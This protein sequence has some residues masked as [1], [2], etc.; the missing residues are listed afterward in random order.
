MSYQLLVRDDSDWARG[1]YRLRDTTKGL[2]SAWSENIWMI[3]NPPIIANK[4]T[5]K[6]YI[7]CEFEEMLSVEEFKERFPELFI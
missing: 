7:V 3:L 5:R 1:K 2:E 6:H 4:T